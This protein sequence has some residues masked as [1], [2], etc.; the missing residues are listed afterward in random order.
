MALIPEAS[1][2]DAIRQTREDGSE[3]WS[4]RDLMPLLGYEK[5]ERFADAVGRA[6][7]SL[8]TQGY[9]PLEN[10]SRLR[11]AIAK[12]T[13]EDFHLSRFACYLVAMN[14]D[15]RKPEV[16]AA[17]A[18][19]AVKTREAEVAPV[20]EL[21]GPEL[22]ARALIEAD[23]TIKAAHA[24]LEVVRAENAE[25][26]P[27]AKAWHDIAGAEGS[28]SVGDSAQMLCSAG[29][30]TGRTRLFAQLDELGWTYMQGNERHI[31]QWA[32]E[33][34][35]LVLRAY[36]PRYKPNG[37]RIQMQPQIRITGKGL[38]RLVREL[39]EAA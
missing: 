36:A 6:S 13:R 30:M 25:L 34:E 20:R 5:W 11:E 9:D 14:G 27:A 19:F 29:I 35:L 10:V 38:D 2:F 22:M 21:T 7:I 12:T 37:E 33:Q 1:P 32:R 39:G 31:K 26:A 16:A 3:F 4:A 15:P 8:E 28:W 17:Q 24:E 23:A 18:Y